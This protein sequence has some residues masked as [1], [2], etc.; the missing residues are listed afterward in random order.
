MNATDIQHLTDDV[1]RDMSNID[2][3]WEIDG[4]MITAEESVVPMISVIESKKSEHT[5]TF[6]TWENEVSF[7]PA[8]SVMQ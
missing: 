3:P 1:D 2:I 4:G 6:W 7:D 5:G 8:L